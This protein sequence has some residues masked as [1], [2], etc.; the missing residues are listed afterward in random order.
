MEAPAHP[1][2]LEQ[3]NSD[4]RLEWAEIKRRYPDQWVVLADTITRD[5]NVDDVS[6]RVLARR[7]RCARVRAAMRWSSTA[8][9][10]SMRAEHLGHSNTSRPQVRFINTAHAR[11]R[12]RPASLR[13]KPSRALE[14]AAWAALALKKAGCSRPRLGAAGSARSVEPGNAETQ[15][16]PFAIALPLND[17]GSLLADIA[18]VTP[19]DIY[20]LEVKWRSALLSDGEV[21]RL[22][23]G[24]VHEFARELPELRMLLDDMGSQQ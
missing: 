16:C 10:G 18:V 19:T 24:R 22:T 21:I 17:E 1:L 20:C 9:I 2:L 4:E 7:P 15:D 5:N 13:G 6:G 23:A 12:W 8:E 14:Q 11:R 3:P